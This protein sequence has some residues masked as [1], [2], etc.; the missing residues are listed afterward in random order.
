MSTIQ[1][2]SDDEIQK[3]LTW[4]EPSK[5]FANPYHTSTR[6]K[7]AFLIMIEAGLRIGECVQLA[8]SDIIKDLKP[9]DV[10]KLPAHITKTGYAR[11]IPTTQRLKD[12]IFR[13]FEMNQNYLYEHMNEYVFIHRSTGKHMSTRHLSRSIK[14]AAKRAIGKSISAHIL[15]HTFATRLLRHTSTRT[16]QLLLGHKSLQSTQ[17]YTHPNSIDLKKAIDNL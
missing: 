1:A 13:F 15:R 11:E 2:L 5:Y 12:Q 16:V 8:W 7:L 4:F 14:A 10:L 9:V 3:F 17:I 6:N